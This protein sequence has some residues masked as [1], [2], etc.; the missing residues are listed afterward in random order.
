MTTCE[1]V[2]TESLKLIIIIIN[3]AKESGKGIKQSSGLLNPKQT[4][5]HLHADKANKTHLS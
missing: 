4:N 3:T 5:N 2:D 1:K